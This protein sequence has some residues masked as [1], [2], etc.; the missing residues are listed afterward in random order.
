M[1]MKIVSS[2]IGIVV[3]MIGAQNAYAVPA[4]Q[5]G[6]NHGVSDAWMP[7]DPSR[8]YYGAYINQTGKGFDHHSAAF[9]EGYTRGWCEVKGYDARLY[10]HANASLAPDFR[11][12]DVLGM[13]LI[14]SLGDNKK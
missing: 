3:L 8:G 2:V 10:P 6:F 12:S 4:F 7:N 14:F 5:T 1:K 11:C 9:N 13:S